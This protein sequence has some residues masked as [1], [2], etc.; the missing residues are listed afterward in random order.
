[1]VT[2]YQASR[3]IRKPQRV[4]SHCWA[5]QHR[6]AADTVTKVFTCGLYDLQNYL[7]CQMCQGESTFPLKKDLLAA[8]NPIFPKTLPVEYFDSQV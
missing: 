6:V 5:H 2:Q 7:S 8:V 1:M 3:R 4:N